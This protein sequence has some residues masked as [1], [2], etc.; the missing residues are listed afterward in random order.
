MRRILAVVLLAVFCLS[1]AAT[2]ALAQGRDPFEPA[3][4]SGGQVEPGTENEPEAEPEGEPETEPEA[5][6]QEGGM[7]NT[8]LETQ[9]WLVLAYVLISVGAGSVFLG[10]ALSKQP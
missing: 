8:G 6:P 7:G 4:D 3:L 1:L 9:P 5:E 2:P 10:R